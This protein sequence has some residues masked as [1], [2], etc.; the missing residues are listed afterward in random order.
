M[1][2]R[3]HDDVARVVE[4]QVGCRGHRAG[5]IEPRVGRDQT[6]AAVCAAAPGRYAFQPCG[7]A[8]EYLFQ[9]FGP[10]GKPGPRERDVADLRR[11]GGKRGQQGENESGPD[12]HEIL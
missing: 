2:E 7:R 1:A 6:R 4:P 11:S 3:Q 12:G 10:V 5:V 9:R 8:I